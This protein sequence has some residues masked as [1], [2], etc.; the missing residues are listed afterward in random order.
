MQVKTLAYDLCCLIIIFS[1]YD[2]IIMSIRAIIVNNKITILFIEDDI[3]IL[4]MMEII[5]TSFEYHV[6]PVSLPEK[7]LQMFQDAPL[8]FDLVVTDY[9][10]PQM[11][12][13]VLA[14]KIRA[15]RPD[16]PIILCSGSDLMMKEV[17][18]RA[19]V[20]YFIN[21]PYDIDQFKLVIEQVLEKKAIA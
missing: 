14:N 3:T 20:D 21:K 6:I 7:A 16:M 15:L 13:E 9:I 17:P 18:H 19:N 11:D 12:G 2:F 4:K 8:S 5:L 1:D 10:M